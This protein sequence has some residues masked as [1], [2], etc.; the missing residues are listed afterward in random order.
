MNQH[1]SIEVSIREHLYDV[2]KMHP[3]FLYA[4]FVVRAIRGHD[5]FAAVFKQVEM[6][7]GCIVRETHYMVS[8]LS[9]PVL[10]RALVGLRSLLCERAGHQPQ[11]HCQE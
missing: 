10:A 3:D 6:M 4:P 1:W 11:H 8:P 5:D 2:R 9:D 7:S